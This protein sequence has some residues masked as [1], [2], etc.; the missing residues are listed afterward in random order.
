MRAPLFSRGTC[1]QQLVIT[2]EV[3][4]RR[5]E[6]SGLSNLGVAYARLGEVEKAAGLLRQAKAIGEEIRDPVI[7]RITTD[8]LEKLSKPE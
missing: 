2:R 1:E 4:D 3:G 5:G 6:G 8:A 7:V